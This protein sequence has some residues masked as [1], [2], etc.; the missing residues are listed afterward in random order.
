MLSLI[1][2]AGN[3]LYFASDFHLGVPGKESSRDRERLILLWLDEIAPQ[4]QAIY[5]V[6]DLFDFWFEYRVVVP[7]GYVR[8]LGKL[9][10]IKDNGIDLQVFT[11][12]H[13][14]WLKNYFPEELGIPV[15]HQ[16]ITFQ[17]GRHTFYVG[18]GDGLGPGDQGYKLIKTIFSHPL[19]QWLFA[20]LHPN[21]AHRLAH[22]WSA[23]SRSA[24]KNEAV[25]L[26]PEKE[27]LIVYCE[28]ILAHQPADFYI[29]GHRH[30]PIDYRLSR[31]Q[32]RYI[33]LGDWLQYHSYAEYNGEDLTLKFFQPD[34]Q[35]IYS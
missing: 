23:Q 33:N 11:G 13:D 29:F 35:V 1:Y 19:S 20:R 25:F 8:F 32:S 4:A 27:W 21:F 7:R 31:N 12:N 22:F 14:L 9:A 24:N 2:M 16:P 18:H 3:K 34:E 15:H 26:G 28:E 5:L 30:L 17:S 6:G 10:E